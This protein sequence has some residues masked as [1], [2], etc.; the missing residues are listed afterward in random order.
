MR[1]AVVI[2]VL[3]EAG[4]IGPTVRGVRGR[5]DEV[6]VVDGDSADATAAEARAAGAEVLVERRRGYG[7]ARPCSVAMTG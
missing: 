4:A 5:V 3:N 2:P 1:V 6:I 7:R